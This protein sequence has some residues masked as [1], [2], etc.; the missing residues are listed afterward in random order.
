MTNKAISEYNQAIKSQ[1]NFAVYYNRGVTYQQLGKSAQVQADFDKAKQ[2]A[3]LGPD[4]RGAW[5][6]ALGATVAP[7]TREDSG[8]ASKDTTGEQRPGPLDSK[9]KASYAGRLPGK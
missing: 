3:I 2:P 9:Q 6:S 4:S 5:T 8:L 1:P 7:G